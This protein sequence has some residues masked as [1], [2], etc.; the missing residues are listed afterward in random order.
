MRAMLSP[1]RTAERPAVKALEDREIAKGYRSPEHSSASR[2]RSKRRSAACLSFLIKAKDEEQASRRIRSTG[3]RQHP[4]E[5]LL[6][7]GCDLIDYTV[8]RESQQEGNLHTPAPV[9]QST[10]RPEYSKPSRTTC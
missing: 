9:F 3:K 10:I 6:Q 7:F 4:A 8:D 1:K 2:K 5:L